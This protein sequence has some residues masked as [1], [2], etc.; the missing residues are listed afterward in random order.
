MPVE[1]Q[2]AVIFAGNQGFLDDLDVSRVG[3]FMDGLRDYLRSQAADV[4]ADI[5]EKLELTD[6]TA[7]KLK[8]AAAAY[9]NSFAADGASIAGTELEA[10]ES[11]ALTDA[12]ESAEAEA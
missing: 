1:E 9:H 2:V 5:R 4:L 8:D 12:A 11:S 6:E 3:P 10:A 7:A